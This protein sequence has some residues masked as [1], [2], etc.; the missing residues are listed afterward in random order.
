MKVLLLAVASGNVI[1]NSA[2]RALDHFEN[3]PMP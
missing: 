2:S 1:I 3:P